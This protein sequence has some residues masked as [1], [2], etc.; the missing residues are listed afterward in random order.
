M[1]LIQKRKKREEMELQNFFSTYR[2]EASSHFLLVFLFSAPQT[3]TL[4]NFLTSGKP[5]M[6]F[7]H[8]LHL[9]APGSFFYLYRTTTQ[10]TLFNF[11]Y[12]LGTQDYGWI[13]E[14][15]AS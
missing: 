9:A 1:F 10:R 4:G 14:N 7:P 8:P 6:C 3:L 12:L 13:N 15:I 2:C 5:N 11:Y